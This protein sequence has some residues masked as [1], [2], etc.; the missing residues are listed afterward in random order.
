MACPLLDNLRLMAGH[1]MLKGMG[2]ALIPAT[3]SGFFMEDKPTAVLVRQVLGAIA[4]FGKASTVAKLAAAQK[5][6]RE[7]T[8]KCEGR[9]AHAELWPDVVKLAKALYRKTKAKRMSLRAIAAE[10]AERHQALQA[11]VYCC[12]W[13]HPN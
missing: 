9:K 6:K 12:G 13:P 11:T 2:I 1:D 5:R 8:G 3:A 4:Q 7:K 10:L